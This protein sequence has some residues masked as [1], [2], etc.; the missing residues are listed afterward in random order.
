MAR[1][2]VLPNLQVFHQPG[3]KDLWLRMSK[4]VLIEPQECRF[5]CYLPNC[6]PVSCLS[7]SPRCAASVWGARPIPEEQWLCLVKTDPT[8]LVDLKE[9]QKNQPVRLLGRVHWHKFV[10]INH[11]YKF[12]LPMCLLL[13]TLT[14]ATVKYM[15]SVRLLLEKAWPFSWNRPVK[16][17]GLAETSHQWDSKSSKSVA[18]HFFFFKIFEFFFREDLWRGETQWFPICWFTPTNGH[19][20]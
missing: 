15:H 18:V 17:F 8:G 19:I 2:C 20:G 4:G 12:M 6:G 16:S 14:C 1:S 10:S 7:L 3:Y 9:S 11:F 5:F 13:W